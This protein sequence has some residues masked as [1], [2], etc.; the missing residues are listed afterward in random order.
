[1][2]TKRALIMSMLVISLGAGVTSCSAISESFSAASA[3]QSRTPEV[4]PSNEVKTTFESFADSVRA[5]N[6]AVISGMY[7]KSEGIAPTASQ[8]GNKLSLQYPQ[9]FAYL[10]AA[11]LGEEKSDDLVLQFISVLSVDP[12]TRIE[13]NESDVTVTGETATFVIARTL[14]GGETGKPMNVPGQIT[15]TKVDGK[16]KITGYAAA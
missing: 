1:M 10:N 6:N 12:K 2:F 8:A 4:Q 11:S 7:K 5:E 13:L 9:S 15:M 16:W 3:S 14:T